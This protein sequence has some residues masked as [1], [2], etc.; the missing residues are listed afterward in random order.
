MSQP[1][2]D[3]FIPSAK[4]AKYD[5]QFIP[6]DT[7]GAPLYVEDDQLYTEWYN[8]TSQDVVL[9]VHIGT[10][11]KNAAWRKAYLEATPARRLEMKS[12]NRI[13]VIKAGQTKQISSDFDLAI[14][15]THCLHPACTNKKDA[16]RDLDHPRV[17]SAGLAPQLICKRWH[18]VPGLAANLDMAKAQAEQAMA[19][20][21]KANVEKL[22]AEMEVQGARKLLEQAQATAREA[23]EAKARAEEAAA[24][25]TK[26]RLEAENKLQSVE[27][28]ARTKGK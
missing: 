10:D 21:A 1:T 20:M 7:P 5:G 24:R 17:V 6:V 22:S 16:C 15:R 13:F 8:P 27:Q 9:E 25:E 14:Q 11:P 23:L 12:G 4:P 26:A 28:A 19:A 2:Q 18:K 3:D